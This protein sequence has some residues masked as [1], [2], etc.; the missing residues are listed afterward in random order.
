M[1]DI[2]DKLNNFIEEDDRCFLLSGEWGV[3]KT[4]IIDTWITNNKLNS[5]NDNIVCLKINLVGVNSVANLYEKLYQSFKTKIKLSSM[6]FGFKVHGHEIYFKF[7]FQNKIRKI[8]KEKKN[9]L[10]VI[11]D[12]ERKDFKLTAAELFGVIDSFHE[13]ENGYNR[14]KTI[15]ISNVQKLSDEQQFNSFKEKVIQKEFSIIEPTDVAIEHLTNKKFYFD[16]KNKGLVIKNLRIINRMNKFLNTTDKYTFKNFRYLYYACLYINESTI[17]KGDIINL[18]M[19]TKKFEK[20]FRKDYNEEKEIENVKTSLAVLDDKNLFA[21]Y[22]LGMESKYGFG[23]SDNSFAYKIYE[24]VKDIDYELFKDTIDNQERDFKTLDWRNLPLL[25]L[26]SNYNDTYIKILDTLDSFLD[27]DEYEL[28]NFTNV[29][30]NLSFKFLFYKKIKAEE[31]IEKENAFINKLEGKIILYFFRFPNVFI[32]NFKNIFALDDFL[33][34]K[35]KDFYINIY[36][37]CCEWLNKIF[38]IEN[39]NETYVFDLI[40]YINSFNNELCTLDYEGEF[41]DFVDYDYIFLNFIKNNINA[42]SNELSQKDWD[43]IYNL[44]ELPKYICVKS[45]DETLEFLENVSSTVNEETKNRLDLIKS[46]LTNKLNDS[47]IFLEAKK[48]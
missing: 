48:K 33:K 47:K 18:I 1:M 32:D 24:I 15:L 17:S 35:L 5:L 21:K 9:I 3:G 41:E 10:I 42:I 37:K 34:L 22:V 27:L 7:D 14:I 38:D 11:D 6:T 8:I 31:I 28:V 19:E 40:G 30:Y 39:I 20:T 36:K 4:F 43:K 23:E 2:Y 13:F 45:F 29:F 44:F 46:K 16:L 25:F 12:I 26:S